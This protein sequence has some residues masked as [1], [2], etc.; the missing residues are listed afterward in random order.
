MARM[1]RLLG[2]VAGSESQTKQSRMASSA[3]RAHLLGEMVGV[4]SEQGMA[5]QNERKD[6]RQ[7][8][9]RTP[10]ESF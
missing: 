5:E 1:D 7:G 8:N 3:G 9:K 4:A 10:L 2:A 6:S